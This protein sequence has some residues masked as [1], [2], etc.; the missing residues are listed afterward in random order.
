MVTLTLLESLATLPDPRSPHGRI[1]PLPA[2]LGM[3]AL[4]MLLGRDSLVGIARFGRQIA[5][6]RPT[7]GASDATKRPRFPPGLAPCGGSMPSNSK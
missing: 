4:A 3:V 6:P 1:H 5:H 7:P 2:I